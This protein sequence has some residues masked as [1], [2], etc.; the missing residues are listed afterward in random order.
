MCCGSNW[1]Y[2]CTELVVFLLL[3]HA[4]APTGWKITPIFAPLNTFQRMHSPIESCLFQTSHSYIKNQMWPQHRNK[5]P[6]RVM[7]HGDVSRCVRTVKLLQEMLHAQ[8]SRAQPQIDLTL[9]SISIVKQAHLWWTICFVLVSFSNL[10][11]LL[12]CL[13]FIRRRRVQLGMCPPQVCVRKLHNE[14]K[15]K[16]VF[17]VATNSSTTSF[18]RPLCGSADDTLY[19]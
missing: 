12:R 13:V 1:I 15:S 17:L 10:S 3:F 2:W 18:Q 19:K 4:K 7:K 9:C 6:T 5:N 11:H 16:S 8:L 14:S